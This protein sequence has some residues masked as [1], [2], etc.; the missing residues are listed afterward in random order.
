MN[1]AAQNA[2]DTQQKL[3]ATVSEITRGCKTKAEMATT[4][5]QW[6]ARNIAY[7]DTL[8]ANVLIESMA[9][10]FKC[11]LE[12]Y[13]YGG[14]VHMEQCLMELQKKSDSFNQEQIAS[15][16]NVFT[17]RK[18]ICSSMAHLL[19]LMYNE[20]GIECEIIVGMAKIDMS[21]TELNALGIN[22]IFMSHAWN[23]AR[24]DGKIMLIDPA[25]GIDE[26]EYFQVAPENLIFTHLPNRTD[27]QYMEKTISI[28]QFVKLPSTTTED[29]ELITLDEM[30]SIIDKNEMTEEEAIWEEVIKRVFNPYLYQY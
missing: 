26:E 2:T 1:V 21:N 20:A 13:V 17:E 23:A 27:Q 14:E 4:I 9:S 15:G 10:A 24:I 7:D 12:F 16:L 3:S 29:W 28:E 18:G 25:W 5:N 6:F 8:A 19:K 30:L 11:I 22:T